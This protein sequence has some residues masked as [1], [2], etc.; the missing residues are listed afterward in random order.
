[1]PGSHG[2]GW[3]M[4]R[5]MRHLR[6]L[7]AVLTSLLVACPGPGDG[8]GFGD[9]DDL[10]GAGDDDDSGAADDDDATG[11]DDDA[12]AD[13]DD[14]TAD[15]DDATGDDD[16]ATGDDDDATAD[17][18]D[19]TG[20]DDDATGDDDDASGPG[21]P[22]TFLT[23]IGCGFT[24]SGVAN[25]SFNNNAWGY[26]A[27]GLASSGWDG[28]EYVVTLGQPGNV[29]LNLTW[30]DASQDLDL[31]VLGGGDVSTSTCFGSSTQSSGTSESLTF[32]LPAGVAAWIIIDGKG[33][34]S[35]NFSLSVTCT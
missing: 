13:D 20:D 28:G 4:M 7:L 11:D 23:G 19:A 14:A 33:A 32:T 26:P 27:C 34:S 8:N 1:M 31:I 9:D 17:D 5:G 24:L 16:D 15:D 10:F 35:D 21:G 29:N 22:V 30:G 12:T 2:A 18:D 3:G 6:L 25:G